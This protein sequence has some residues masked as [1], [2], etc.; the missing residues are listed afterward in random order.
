MKYTIYEPLFGIHATAALAHPC[1]AFRVSHG[2]SWAFM[3]SRHLN[4]PVRQRCK[5]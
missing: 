3:P 5:R 2:H 1:A 4:I